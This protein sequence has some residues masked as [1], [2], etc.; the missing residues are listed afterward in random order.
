MLDLTTVE[1]CWLSLALIA[2][3]GILG[4]LTPAS[5]EF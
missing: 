1:T 2:V 5:R 3:A 4:I